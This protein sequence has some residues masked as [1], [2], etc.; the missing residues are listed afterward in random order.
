M[1]EPAEKGFTKIDV[2]EVLRSKNPRLGKL[3]PSFAV[4][5]LKR[6]I[7]ENELN[8]FLG[9]SG[10]LKDVALVE[11]SLDFLN[12]RYDVIGKENIPS[13]GRH[14]FVSNHPLG[15]LDGVIFM[16]EL[17]RHF[18]DIKFPVNDILTNIRNLSGIFIPVNKHGAQ[19]R[20]AARVLEEA[21]ASDCQ[22]LYFPAGL[23]SRKKKGIIC[24][25][26]WQKNFIVKAVR[27]KRDIVPAF[28]SGRN[29][30]FFYNLAR[31][32]NLL[33]IRA[34]IEMLY[35]PDEM[36]RQRGKKITL[37]FGRAIPWTTFDDSKTPIEWADW[38]K[39][40][41]YELESFIPQ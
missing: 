23:C 10:H 14:I 20:E 22:I 30:E 7:H 26:Q 29:S 35:L 36:F 21:Y 13:F 2:R 25:L 39:S 4:N 15:G 24:D 34:N 6:I 12:I 41:S 32:R 17:S 5:Y 40:R 27:H 11:A 16:Y 38:V 8:E 1:D 31:L 3:I 37:V 18:N 33:G 19:G 28:F 9:R